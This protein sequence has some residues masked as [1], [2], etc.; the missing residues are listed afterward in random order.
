VG[1]AIARAE[2]LAGQVQHVRDAHKQ[3]YSTF[4]GGW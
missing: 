4:E 3:S 1:Q 2:L